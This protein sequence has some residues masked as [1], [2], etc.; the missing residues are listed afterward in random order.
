MS[1]YITRKWSTYCNLHR[2]LLKSHI[3]YQPFPPIT[4][5]INEVLHEDNEDEDKLPTAAG[6][7]WDG[8]G[9]TFT[10]KSSRKYSWRINVF[11]LSI[12]T[13]F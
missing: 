4:D 1:S 10:A 2:N 8:G 7:D 13:R 5:Y 9:L 12:R 11:V 6:D 3:K